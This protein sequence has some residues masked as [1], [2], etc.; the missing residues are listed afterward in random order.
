ME[1][2][3]SWQPEQSLLEKLI[4]LARQQGESPEAII[5][6]AVRQYLAAATVERTTDSDP[7][8]GLFAS[9]PD[10]ATQSENILEQEIT[11]KSGW[12]W[13]EPLS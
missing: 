3:F 11:H 6:E 5:T 4:V 12:T 7:L 9:S 2:T 13:K 8:I 1:Q 10:L